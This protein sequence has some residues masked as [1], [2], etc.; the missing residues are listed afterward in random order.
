MQWNKITKVII[1]LKINRIQVLL[2]DAQ[3]GNFE[4]FDSVDAQMLI[5][6]SLAVAAHAASPHRMP[7][8]SHL[9]SY[10]LL[11]HFVIFGCVLNV[12]DVPRQ[13]FLQ[14]DGCS[15][16]VGGKFGMKNVD[17]ASIRVHTTEDFALFLVRP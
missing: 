4:S 2:T 10:P 1:I 12:G 6:N 8:G 3:I 13:T 17:F 9:F 15:A 5:Y 11:D 7:S 16:G 14:L